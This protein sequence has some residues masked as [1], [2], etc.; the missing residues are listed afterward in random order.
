MEWRCPILSI[1]LSWTKL[2]IHI[3]LL[4]LTVF[5]FLY[6]FLPLFLFSRFLFVL[7]LFSFPFSRGLLPLAHACK[8]LWVS[9]HP[10]SENVWKFTCAKLCNLVNLKT[11]NLLINPHLWP[12][13][14]QSGVTA[15]PA[16]PVVPTSLN[17]INPLRDLM[18][19]LVLDPNLQ[20]NID[21]F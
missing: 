18:T 13:V 12:R 8:R 21:P 14:P 2:G 6:L 19:N 10:F 1:R 7:F 3:I 16:D 15:D 4:W 20:M 11:S 5:S 9:M 17:P